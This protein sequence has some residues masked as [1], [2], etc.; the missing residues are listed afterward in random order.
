MTEPEAAGAARRAFIRDHHPDRGGDPA[1][2]VD[3]L[4][5]LDGAASP[6]PGS[7]PWAV[8]VTV[9]RGRRWSIARWARRHRRRRRRVRS[10]RVG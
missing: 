9:F 10:R 4:R 5:R 8:E 2:F 3:G 1:R 7:R 6:A